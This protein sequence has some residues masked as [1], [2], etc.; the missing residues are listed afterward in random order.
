MIFFLLACNIVLLVTGQTLW[1]IGLASEKITLSLN[2]LIQCLINPYILTGLVLYGLATIIW[3][4]LLSR[5]EL[6][7]IYP[8]QSICYVAAAFIALIVFKEH[9]PATRWIGISLIILGAYFV[10]LK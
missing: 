10:A 4:Y 5:A 1:K 6:S 8:L 2:S 9:L 7:L 3:F